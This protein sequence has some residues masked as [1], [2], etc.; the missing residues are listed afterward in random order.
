MTF[1]TWHECNDLLREA[2]HTSGWND[3]AVSAGNALDAMDDEK[4]VALIDEA[5]DRKPCAEFRDWLR[6]LKEKILRD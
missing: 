5:L 6:E 2:S 4:C 3:L 1:A